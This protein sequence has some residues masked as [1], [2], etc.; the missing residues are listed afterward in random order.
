[1]SSLRTVVVGAGQ[2]GL[3][4]A[5]SLR[6]AGETGP[7]LLLGDEPSAPYQRP[8]LSKA[9]LA[10]KVDAAGLLLRPPE[11]LVAGG[12]EWRGGVRVEAI[13]RADARLET[14]GGERIAYDRLVLATGVR[15][16]RLMLPGA[17]L[18]GVLSVRTLADAVVLQQVLPAARDVVVIGGGF[19]G[20]EVA[21]LVAAARGAGAA[22]VRVLEAAPRALAR[23]ASPAMSAEVTARLAAAGVVVEAGAAVAGLEGRDGRVAG[24]RLAAGDLVPAD[25]V[26]VGIGAVPNTELAVGAGL[27]VDNGIAVDAELGTSDPAIAAIGDCASF[28]DARTGQRIRLE[29]VQNAV[30]QARH[31][32]ARFAGRAGP[33]AAVPWFWSDQGPLKIQIAG[34]TAGAD[35]V[36]PRIDAAG[37]TMLCFAGGRFLGAETINRP[38]DHMAVRR[39]LA[40]GTELDPATAADPAFDLR[41]AA[42]GRRHG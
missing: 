28:P 18:A 34:L 16:R 22:P 24:V 29:S 11:A 42:G 15:N 14:A 9:F 26:I 41:A 7:I 32:A 21:A 12:I 25:L 36:L 27:V 19:I 5:L 40:A 38:G 8:P 31:L 3:Q 30:D 17:D 37:A 13:D 10:D 1:M 33:Y 39:L 35:L 4:L 20:L 6:E 23:A 2:A